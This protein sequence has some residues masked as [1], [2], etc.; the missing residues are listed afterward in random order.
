[1]SES[2]AGLLTRETREEMAGEWDALSREI[3]AE[4]SG[5]ARAERQRFYEQS[6]AVC[7]AT[8]LADD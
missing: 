6:L 3:T 7:V 8:V 5:K 4:I 2:I 1:M